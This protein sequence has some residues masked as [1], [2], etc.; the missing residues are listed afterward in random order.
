MLRWLSQFILFAVLSAILGGCVLKPEV[1][2]GRDPRP[3]GSTTANDPVIGD[4][5]VYPI[6]PDC[7]FIYQALSGQFPLPESERLYMD[8]VLYEVSGYTLDSSSPTGYVPVFT[9]Q[10]PFRVGIITWLIIKVQHNLN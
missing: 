9:E 2:R 6:D 10:G 3:P 1:M 5:S 8:L 4:P 7:F